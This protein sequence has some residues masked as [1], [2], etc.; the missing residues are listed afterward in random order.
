MTHFKYDDPPPIATATPVAPVWH[1]V[2]LLAII[3]S[4][5]V[6]GAVFKNGVLFSRF[7]LSPS[8]L[9]ESRYL[10]SIIMQWLLLGFVVGY[11]TRRGA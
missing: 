3:L 10:A 4:A 11:H 5:S 1:T 7:D 8:V 9:R 6:L 2:V